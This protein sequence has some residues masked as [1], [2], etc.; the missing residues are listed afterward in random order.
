MSARDVWIFG[1]G[2]LMWRPGFDYEER[3]PALLVGYGRAFCVY[4]VWHRGTA[5]NPGLVLGLDRGGVCKG[6]AYRVAAAKAA[7]TILYLRGREQVTCVYRESVQ[8]VRLLGE[9]GA[10]GPD[11]VDAVCYVAERGHP[12]Y[13]GRLSAADQAAIIRYARGRSGA[14]ADYLINTVLHLRE[15]GFR[16][17]GLE[18]VA[19]LV[20]SL[21]RDRHEQ[22]R[23]DP[24][25]IERPRGTPHAVKRAA[26]TLSRGALA[27]F[28][29]RR[30]MPLTAGA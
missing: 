4:S 6:M 20:G 5:H 16:D 19:A 25:I 21:E 17:R 2:S 27:R 24:V 23:P 22:H 3:S 14:N 18:R 30:R 10:E 9:R 8:P 7:E 11:R 28:G 15:L 12:Q 1:Y 29:F 13:A 26:T